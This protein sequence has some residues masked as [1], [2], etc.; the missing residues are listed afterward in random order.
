[1]LRIGSGAV[2]SR[3]FDQPDREPTKCYQAPRSVPS[4]KGDANK[5]RLVLELRYSQ[6]N[7][8][9]TE[10]AFQGGQEQMCGA[11]EAAAQHAHFRT[12][13]NQQNS[14]DLPEILSE[15]GEGLLRSWILADDLRPV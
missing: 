3:Y 11:G 13:I 4:G 6:L 14:N 12:E 15:F 7:R 10:L 8:N 2:S 5:R 1:M 9:I